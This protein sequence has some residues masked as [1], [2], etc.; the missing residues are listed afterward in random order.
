MIEAELTKPLSMDH[1]NEGNSAA[2][3]RY[4]PGPA[5][6]TGSTYALGRRGTCGFAPASG[7]DRR[8][9]KRANCRETPAD[10]LPENRQK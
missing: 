3:P 4:A 5:V 2:L 1:E 7:P 10:F 9:P 8:R 6:L